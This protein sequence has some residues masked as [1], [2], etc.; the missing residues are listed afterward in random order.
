MAAKKSVKSKKSTAVKKPKIKVSTLEKLASVQLIRLGELIARDA[1]RHLE[2]PF[3]LRGT[4]LHILSLL[5]AEGAMTVSQIGR[6]ARIDKAWVSRSLT[7]LGK[8]N[9]ITRS[10]DPEDSRAT[11][12]Y[13]SDE[14]LQVLADVSPIATARQ[15]RLLKGVSVQ[16]LRTLIT[17]LSANVESMLDDE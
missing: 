3:G 14:G 13:L 5:A 11:R 15:K 16:E 4:E 10:A 2:A 17:A 6:K 8:R 1:G 7:E 9:L 12:I